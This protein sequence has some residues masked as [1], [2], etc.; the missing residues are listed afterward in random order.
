[1]ASVIPAKPP[2]D[3]MSVISRKVRRVTE[4]MSLVTMVSLKGW[5]IKTKRRRQDNTQISE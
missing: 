1:M 3:C 5:I 4:R 2:G